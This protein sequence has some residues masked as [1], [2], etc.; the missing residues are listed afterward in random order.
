MKKSEDGKVGMMKARLAI[1]SHF[2]N[3]TAR[4]MTNYDTRSYT[5]TGSER[6]LNGT[7]V[8]PK[9]L[10]GNV[11]VGSWDNL[12]TPQIQDVDGQ[13]QF[14]ENP[15]SPENAQGSY[16]QSI[17]F[18][19]P[20]DARYFGEHYKEIAPMMNLYLKEGNVVERFRKYRRGGNLQVFRHGGKGVSKTG[21]Y[22][23]QDYLG[24]SGDMYQAAYGALKNLGLPY[25]THNKIANLSRWIA[26]HKAYESGYGKVVSNDFNYGGY[27]GKKPIKFNSI[28]DYVTRYVTDAQRLYPGIF[29]A[30]NYQEYIQALFPDG[31]GYNPRDKNGNLTS[32]PNKYDKNKSF[33]IYWRD[34]GGMQKRVNYNIDEW[35]NKGY[36]K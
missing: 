12:V 23:A 31:H 19:S 3:P 30:N 15:W 32:D 24:F 5:F 17:I 14:I 16:Q 20:E 28:N 25:L 4:R 21:Q 10:K 29:K 26:M 8:S 35:L 36:N 22:Q 18:D 7:Q 11:Y 6:D 1:A 33:E 2:G 34:S 13:L 9:G 27:G